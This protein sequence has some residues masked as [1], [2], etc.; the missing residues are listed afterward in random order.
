MLLITTRIL[1]LD[2]NSF[3]IEGAAGAHHSAFATTMD[4]A[5]V[6]ATTFLVSSVDPLIFCS[7]QQE[8][9]ERPSLHSSVELCLE[10]SIFSLLE[11]WELF[12]RPLLHQPIQPLLIPFFFSHFITGGEGSG[13]FLVLL[14]G[15]HLVIL[16]FSF[17]NRGGCWS[18]SF[19]LRYINQFCP[20]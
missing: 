16:T 11:L 17:C 19:H 5:D 8:G 6:I 20:C 18:S 9:K 4:A 15:L 1:A 7:S 12:L 14:N 10:I 2:L 13:V 3:V